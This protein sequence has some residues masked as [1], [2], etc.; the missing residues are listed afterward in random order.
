MK[1]VDLEQVIGQ[2]QPDPWGGRPRLR[3]SPH[4]SRDDPTT[5]VTHSPRTNTAKTTLFKI[6]LNMSP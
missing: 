6:P 3:E 1:N 2:C 4:R 5:S